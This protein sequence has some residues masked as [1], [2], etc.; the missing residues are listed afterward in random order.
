[1]NLEYRVKALEKQDNPTGGHL[2]GLAETLAWIY[3]G[4][5]GPR[6]HLTLTEPSPDWLAG[7]LERAKARL[8][9]G[10]A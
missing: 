1:M 6:P 3:A 10:S 9:N 2:S 4:R 5:V 7:R 8:A